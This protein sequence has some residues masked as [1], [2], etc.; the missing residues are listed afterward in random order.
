[1]RIRLRTRP[2]VLFGAL[3][4]LALIALLPLRLVL[5]IV[6]VGEQGLTARRVLGSV[7]SGTMVEASFAGIPLGDLRAR[8]SPWP[9]LI[10][11]AR[12]ELGGRAAPADR[13]LR[14]AITLSR[15]GIAADDLTASVATGGLFAPLPVTALDLDAVT[16]HFRDGACEAAQGRVR[17]TLGGG[18]AGIVFP[19]SV[20]GDAR[21]DGAALLLP[22]TSQAGSEGVT[23]RI[24]GNGTYAADCLVRPADPTAAVALEAAGFQ[25]SASG[26]RLSVQGRF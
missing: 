3:L 24:G 11:R 9:L 4:A 5:G 14:G 10:G 18:V 6:G 13:A 23:L 8:L 1:L 17:A 25:P 21:C 22:L 2:G 26:H 16:V 7:W 15:H 19:A 20:A 12:I